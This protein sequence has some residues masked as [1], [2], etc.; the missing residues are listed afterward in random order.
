MIGRVSH[1]GHVVRGFLSLKSMEILFL[2]GDVYNEMAMFGLVAD[3]AI[4][5]A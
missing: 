3:E 5:N 2:N 1:T 4:V